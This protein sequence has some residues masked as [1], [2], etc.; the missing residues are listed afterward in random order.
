MADNEVTFESL[1]KEMAKLFKEYGDDVNKILEEEMKT[2]S[3]E[4]TSQ[5]KK[6]SPK[7][8]G[9]YAKGWKF[10]L[11]KTRLGPVTTIYNATHAW[12]VHLLE[13][14]HAKRNGGRTKAEPHVKPAE[15]WAEKELVKRVEERLSK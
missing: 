4:T 3:K 13:H 14:G 1:G 7:G 2:V 15:D 10:K 6:T 8:R 12:L 11:E 5:L 9:D